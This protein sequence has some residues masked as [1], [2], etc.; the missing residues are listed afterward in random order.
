MRRRYLECEA[1]ILFGSRLDEFMRSPAYWRGEMMAHVILK[2][3]REQYV[4]HVLHEWAKNKPK[5]TGY[6]PVEAQKRRW[7]VA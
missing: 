6:N 2:R 7:A 4:D 1:A 3:Q 5:K